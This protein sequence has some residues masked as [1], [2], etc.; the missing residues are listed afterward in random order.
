MNKIHLA[1]VD[2]GSLTF[3][4]KYSFMQELAALAGQRVEV[5]IRKYRK[6]RSNNQNAYYHGVVVKLISDHT[7]YE[8]DEVHEILKQLFFSKEIEVAGKVLMIATTTKETTSEWEDRMSQIRSWASIEL[9]VFIPEP[10]AVL[11]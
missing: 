1:T 6:R 9:G 3:D 11:I 7:G 4:D 5:V 10:N 2:R 8:A